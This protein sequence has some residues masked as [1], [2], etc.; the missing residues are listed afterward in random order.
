M[1]DEFDYG[2]ADGSVGCSLPDVRYVL[3]LVLGAAVVTAALGLALIRRITN[4][5]TTRHW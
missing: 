4:E 5:Q 1:L 3:A 2:C